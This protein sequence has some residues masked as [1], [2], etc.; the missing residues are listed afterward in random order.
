MADRLDIYERDGFRC[1]YCGFDG[2]TF[3]TFH[4]LQVDHINP[5][6]PRNDPSNLVTACSYCNHCKGNDPCENVEQAKV[7]LKKHDE[8]NRAYWAKNV[9]FR[10]HR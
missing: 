3:E 6:G 8:L 7:L 5:I 9:A 4:Y 10:V 1:V 2:G